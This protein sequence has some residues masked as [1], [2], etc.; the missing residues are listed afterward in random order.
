MKSL[1]ITILFLAFSFVTSANTVE[2]SATQEDAKPPENIQYV[3]PLQSPAFASYPIWGPGMLPTS[4]MPLSSLPTTMEAS[5]QILG[6]TIRNT[7]LVLLMLAPF[8]CGLGAIV[9]IVVDSLSKEKKFS[10]KMASGHF[11]VAF[12]LGLVVSLYFIGTLNPSLSA[13]AKLLGFTVL[14]GYQAPR[15]WAMQEGILH[16]AIDQRLKLIVGD[17]EQTGSK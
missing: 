16:K 15:F 7:D 3:N 5:A 10:I 14:L 9:F 2:D 1:L 13:I 4:N 17:R 11:F 6:M 12:V 8:C